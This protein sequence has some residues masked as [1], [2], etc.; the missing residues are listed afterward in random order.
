MINN[1]DKNNAKAFWLRMTE[2]YGAKWVNS[3]GSEPTELWILTIKQLPKF[4]I[5]HA[6]HT[7]MNSGGS[8]VPTLPEFKEIARNAPMP[9][10]LRQKAVAHERRPVSKEQCKRNLDK[11]RKM[12][13]RVGENDE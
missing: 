11:L 13:S 7:L 8:F 6:M 12:L 4:R 2:I 10:N 3:Y 5:K 1:T 9:P